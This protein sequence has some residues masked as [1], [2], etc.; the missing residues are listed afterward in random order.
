MLAATFVAILATILAAILATILVLIGLLQS[1][2]A[3]LKSFIG[4]M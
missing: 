4:M 2:A 3:Y 1:P